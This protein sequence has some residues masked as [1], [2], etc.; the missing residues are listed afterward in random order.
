M[1]KLTDLVCQTWNLS[2]EVFVFQIQNKWPISNDRISMCL[3]YFFF[4]QKLEYR[5]FMVSYLSLSPL[6]RCTFGECCMMDLRDTLRWPLSK[7][8]VYAHFANKE[9]RKEL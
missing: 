1:I 3:Y 4:Y 8:V 2:T 6:S 5:L 9:M 7:E